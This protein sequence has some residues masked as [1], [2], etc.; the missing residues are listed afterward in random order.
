MRRKLIPDKRVPIR[1]V[2]NQIFGEPTGGGGIIPTGTHPI[3]S[4]SG[5]ER[6]AVVLKERA[7]GGIAL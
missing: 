4:R 7:L 5:V 1:A 6:L 3:I 2:P